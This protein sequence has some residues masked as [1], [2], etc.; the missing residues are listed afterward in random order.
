MKKIHLLEE[1][2]KDDFA[3]EIQNLSASKELIP[4]KEFIAEFDNRYMT[5][6]NPEDGSDEEAMAWGEVLDDMGGG[7]AEDFIKE[8]QIFL[9]IDLY[10]G[11]GDSDQYLIDGYKDMDKDLKELV[12]GLPV[13]K[14]FS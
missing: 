1:M 2:S 10:D 9:W 6:H 4:S 14:Y 3:K 8:H 5:I 11:A 12:K 7:K 13:E